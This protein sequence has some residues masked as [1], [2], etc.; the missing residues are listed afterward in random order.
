M[1]DPVPVMVLARL[2]VGLRAQGIKLG[3]TLLQDAVCREQTVSEHVSAPALLVHALHEH[4]RQFYE[5]Y[6]F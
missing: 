2:A 6:G 3:A 4:A 5:R 1:P